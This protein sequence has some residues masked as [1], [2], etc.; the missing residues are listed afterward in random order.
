[1]K[2]SIRLSI[3]LMLTAM[4]TSRTSA[5]EKAAADHRI[6][7]SAGID[8]GYSLGSFKHTHKWDFGG[9]LQADVPVADKFYAVIN[10]GYNNF[11]GKDNIYGTSLSATDIHLLPVKA[12][13]KYFPIPHFYGQ[14]TAG[15]AFALNK[16][17]VG[18]TS[19]A[20]FI[21]A[22]QLGYQMRLGGVSLLDAGIFYQA[23]TKFTEAVN[24]SKIN[25]P[26]LRIAYAFSLK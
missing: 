6:I 1:M 21:Y 2:T 22:P 4:V 13:L 23:S 12:G 17:D 16:K 20:A 5:Q 11:F 9:S 19:T 24:D 14:A 25:Y 18:Y 15:A 7:Y 8:G 26:G 10:A 3:L